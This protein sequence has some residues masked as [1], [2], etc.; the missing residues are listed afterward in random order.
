MEDYL[1]KLTK[2]I[3]RL[4]IDTFFTD[5]FVETLLKQKGKNV[6]YII[7]N[8]GS[9]ANAIHIA[10]DFTYGAVM[11]TS[12]TSGFN[13]DALSSNQGVIT[14]L[15][16]D[17]G[18]EN[19]F[20]YQLKSKAKPDDVLLA[21]SGSGNSQNILNAVYCANEL[22]MK[23]FS[24]TGYNGGKLK[25]L[26]HYNLHFDVDDMQITEDMQLIFGHYC[27]KKINKLLRQNL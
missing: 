10:N 3:E 19:I 15:A 21:L 11:N 12:H 14:C 25:K 13:V 20:S 22:D 17:I 5:V 24:I 4:E 1:K 7:G 23:T 26:T 2:S 6:L 27:M 18:Y 16:N 8:G 9:A